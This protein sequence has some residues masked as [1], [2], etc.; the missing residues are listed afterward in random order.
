MVNRTEHDSLTRLSTAELRWR[1]LNG[2]GYTA[3]KR[4]VDVSNNDTKQL[5]INNTHDSIHIGIANL[6]ITAEGKVVFQPAFNVTEDTEGDLADG[7]SNKRSKNG[8]TSVGEVRTGGDGETG[9]YSGGRTLPEG[10]SG[11]GGSAVSRNPGNVKENG[12]AFAIDPGDNMLIDVTN[13]SG[14]TGDISIR[15]NWVDI[16]G[17]DYP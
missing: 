10:F 7:P 12:I 15:F 16:P 17:R 13:D 14:S 5:F 9:A 6:L 2:D 4:F 11:S 1:V 3:G 8:S